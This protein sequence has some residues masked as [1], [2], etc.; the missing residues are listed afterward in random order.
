MT[1]D[2]KCYE[3]AAGFVADVAGLSDR[4]Q[5]N[6]A[7]ALAQLIQETIEDFLS[8]LEAE[9]AGE[10]DREPQPGDTP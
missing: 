3:L 9:I 7:H 10:A 4:D 1:Y 2:S 6:C 5:T 8:G